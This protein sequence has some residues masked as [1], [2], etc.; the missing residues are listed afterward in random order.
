[1]AQIVDHYINHITADEEVTIPTGLLDLDRL[2]NGGLRPLQ[3]YV[4]K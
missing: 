4:T 2:L 3:G 1:M